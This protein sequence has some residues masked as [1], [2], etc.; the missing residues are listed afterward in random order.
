MIMNLLP[1]QNKTHRG[2]I[3]IESAIVMIAFVIVAAALSFVVLNMGLSTTQQA[4]SAITDSLSTVSGSLQVGGTAVGIG[5]VNAG[6]INATMFPIATAGGGAVN[7]DPTV[8]VV[9]YTANGIQYGNIFSP[10]S[11]LLKSTTYNSINASLVAAQAIG[12]I[13]KNPMVTGGATGGFPAATTAIIYF[14]AEKNTNSVLEGGEVANLVIVYKQADR[15]TQ[16]NS[17]KAELIPSV[18]SVLTITRTIPPI[19]NSYVDLG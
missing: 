18:G 9:S 19:L 13:S 15:P 17:F 2:V 5:H 12:C 7:L 11:C 3:G 4:K 1:K 14:S 6:A 16:T 8:T 10:A